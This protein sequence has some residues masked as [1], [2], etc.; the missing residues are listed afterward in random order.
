[1]CG[2]IQVWL[3]L[4]WNP[5]FT[6]FNPNLVDNFFTKRISP[7]I[8]AK[9]PILWLLSLVTGN[10][11]V[12]ESSFERILLFNQIFQ[13]VDLKK[14]ISKWKK[15]FEVIV[16]VWPCRCHRTKDRYVSFLSFP[17][18]IHLFDYYQIVKILLHDGV[19]C[20]IH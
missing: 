17:L 9:F 6:S 18:F 12:F 8:V 11:I 15:C 10:C 1:M 14:M 3:I 16:S 13:S 2:R 5:F 4:K 20:S 7:V 19:K